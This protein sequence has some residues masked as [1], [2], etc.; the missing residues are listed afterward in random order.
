MIDVHTTPYAA[1]LL[2][3][4]LGVLFLAC[5]SQA[6]RI[7]ALR[8]SRI[9]RFDRS[10]TG[11]VLAYVTCGNSPAPP[12]SSEHMRLSG[13]TIKRH[14]TEDSGRPDDGAESLVLTAKTRTSRW[15]SHH[16][17]AMKM[18]KRVGNLQAHSS[19]PIKGNDAQEAASVR[20]AQIPA[21]ARYHGCLLR[22][23]LRRS[24]CAVHRHRPGFRRPS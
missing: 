17:K 21:A 7:H 14:S 19:I 11:A 6:L 2:R 22:A 12:R 9:F 13:G 24:E 8:H 5:R 3:L 4:T 15:A 23:G 18:L 10:F 1:L 20:C 16:S